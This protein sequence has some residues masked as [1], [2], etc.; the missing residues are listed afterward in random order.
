MPLPQYELLVRGQLR[1][2]VAPAGAVVGWCSAPS[3]ARESGRADE[4]T[5]LR[6]TYFLILAAPLPR[7]GAVRSPGLLALGE[8]HP[9]EP[10]RSHHPVTDPLHRGDT[11]KQEIVERVRVLAAEPDA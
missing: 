6:S 10:T 8:H 1:C 5:A 4:K 11:E 3:A 7:D 2:G 9:T